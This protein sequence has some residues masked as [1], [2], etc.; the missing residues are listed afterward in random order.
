MESIITTKDRQIQNLNGQIIDAGKS[1]D[2]I[3]SEHVREAAILE[4]LQQ[5][6]A[7]LESFVYN[8]KNN[9]DEYIKIIKALRI[10]Y[11]SPYQTKRDFYS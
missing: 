7:R 8:Y 6:T 10:R 11:M 5:Q 4:C 3:K 9:D 2:A 1:L